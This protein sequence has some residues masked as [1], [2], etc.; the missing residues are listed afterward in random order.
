MKGEATQPS[1]SAAGYYLTWLFVNL[2]YNA[3][4]SF[5]C[6]NQESV[7]IMILFT[8]TVRHLVCLALCRSLYRHQDKCKRGP[9]SPNFASIIQ[10]FLISVHLSVYSSVLLQYLSIYLSVYL[11]DCN[12]IKVKFV[13]RFPYKSVQMQ[14]DD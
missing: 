11:S 1:S 9:I 2:S 4:E 6:G 7:S 3:A 14:N 12:V 5:P 10:T 13:V 8:W